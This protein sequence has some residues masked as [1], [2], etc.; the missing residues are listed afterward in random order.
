MN[1]C[2]VITAESKRLT[3]Y[4]GGRGGI[5]LRIEGVDP[6]LDM[7]VDLDSGLARDIGEALIALADVID[8]DN[9]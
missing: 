2:V 8:E 9:E 1:A 3:V 6:D 7:H 5:T 4:S